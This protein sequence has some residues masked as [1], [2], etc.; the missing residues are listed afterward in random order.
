AFADQAQHPAAF[1]RQ[2]D[3]VEHRGEAG[4]GRK[5]QRQFFDRQERRHFAPAPRLM[6][7]SRKSRSPSPKRLKP[8]TTMKIAMPGAVAYHHASGRNSRD[9]AIMRPH[10][11]VGGGAPRPRKPNA[12]AVRM[13]APM[14]IEVRTMMVDAMLGSTCKVMMRNGE[15]P[16]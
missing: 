11:G 14:P 2:V 13:V 3:S 16:S 10:S 5:A 6:R 4:L 8:M 9:A 15:A 7:G 1:D 12:A